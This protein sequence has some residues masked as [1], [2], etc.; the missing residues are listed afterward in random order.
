[1]RRVKDKAPEIVFDT[2][3]EVIEALRDVRKGGA[4]SVNGILL[5]VEEKLDDVIQGCF[6]VSDG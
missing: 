6:E 1:M 4:H 5:D 2:I 3:E